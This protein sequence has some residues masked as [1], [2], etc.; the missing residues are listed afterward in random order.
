MTILN[1]NPMQY[2]YQHAKRNS[3]LCRYSRKEIAM[4]YIDGTTPKTLIIRTI[5]AAVA[6]TINAKESNSNNKPH[7][8]LRVLLVEK[9]MCAGVVLPCLLVDRTVQSSAWSFGCWYW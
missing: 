4:K 8:H 7:V 1:E 2:D 9:L 3:K 6:M 5:R